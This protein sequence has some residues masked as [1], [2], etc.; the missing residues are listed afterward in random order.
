MKDF[1]LRVNEN[2]SLC[3]NFFELFVT[4]CFFIFVEVILYFV[5]AV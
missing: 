1:Y 5:G 4:E 2:P 3:I